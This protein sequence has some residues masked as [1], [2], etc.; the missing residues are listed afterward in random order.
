[1]KLENHIS[2][3]QKKKDSSVSK[4][5]VKSKHKHEYVECLFI[6]NGTPHRGT[7]CKICGKIGEVRWFET[8][9]LDNGMWKQIDYDEVYEKYSHMEKIE[10]EDMFQ[11]Y[12]CITK[13]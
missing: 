5:N 10:I 13:R 1:M 11:K 3:H 8:E 7:H 4:S 12:V 2:R 6:N 9:K